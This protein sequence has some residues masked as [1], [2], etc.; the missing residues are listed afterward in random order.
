MGSV[1]TDKIPKLIV[2]KAH[3]HPE[4]KHKEE[5]EV[6]T[7]LQNDIALIELLRPLNFSDKVQP[8]CL[9]T[10]FKETYGDEATVAGW[11]AH[12]GKV[13]RRRCLHN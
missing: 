9:P 4:W 1:D 12:D 7:L 2:K 8:I 6:T 5:G 3:V 10:A 13:A 11:G